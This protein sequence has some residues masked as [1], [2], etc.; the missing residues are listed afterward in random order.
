VYALLMA[1]AVA[2]APS[3]E[4]KKV[5]EGAQPRI[6]Q[7]YGEVLAKMRRP[8]PGKVRTSFV[9]T[10]DGYVKD[11][12]LVKKGTTVKDARFN[13]CVVAVLSTLTFPKPKDGKDH[14]QEFPFN[15]K[16]IK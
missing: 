14:P 10:P 8:V 3:P 1:L 13:E 11:A 16:A 6:Q 15:L 9:V 2:A 12:K 4:V 5:M 7:C